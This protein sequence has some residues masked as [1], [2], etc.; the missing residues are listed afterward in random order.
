MAAVKEKKPK[1]PEKDRWVWL[2][3][4]TGPAWRAKRQAEGYSTRYLAQR[5][6]T[7]V[8]TISNVETEK[9]RRLDRALFLRW[10]LVLFRD[11]GDDTNDE[12]YKTLSDI[13]VN[14]D[15]HNLSRLINIAL[16]LKKPKKP[17]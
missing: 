3:E 12:Q 13:M 9:Q 1:E 11:R 2:D 15:G 17:Q 8:G 16:E 5:I 10:K 6:G 14:M 4:G 7:S